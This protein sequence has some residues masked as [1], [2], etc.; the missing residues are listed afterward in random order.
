MKFGVTPSGTGP[1]G[2]EHRS[3]PGGIDMML[4]NDATSRNEQ[5]RYPL[6]C[7]R[8]LRVLGGLQDPAGREL[9]KQTSPGLAR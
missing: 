8:S 7:T 5:C 1:A 6:G 4:F 3:V 9:E 2:M